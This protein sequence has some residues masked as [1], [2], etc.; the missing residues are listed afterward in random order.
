MSASVLRRTIKRTALRTLRSAGLYSVAAN[1]AARKH[2]LLILCYHGI[3]LR[4]EHKWAG[5]LFITADR[6]RQRLTCLRELGAEVLPLGEA[7]HRLTARNLPSR[8]VTITFDDGFYDFFH[9]AT[10]I[11][12]EF[13]YPAT[14]YLTTY[15]SGLRIPIV[16]LI[17]DYLLW[18][19]E[20]NSMRFPDQGIQEPVSITTWQERMQAVQRL[21][22]WCEAKKLDTWAKNEFARSVAE[23]LNIDYDDLLRSRIAQIMTP[24]EAA[25]AARKGIDIQLHSHRHRTPRDHDLFVRE[26]KDNSSRIEEITGKVPTHFCYPSGD[27]AHEFLPWLRECGVESA[28]TCERGFA[29]ANTEPLLLPRILDDSNMDIVEF[30]ALVS[31]LLA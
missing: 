22:S 6:L 1:S 21:L 11:L 4:D 5:H 18:K 28:T 24:D 10:P 27:Y 7:L 14:L 13:G 16:N 30:E 31:G 2:K 9:H 26:I 29:R 20:R 23:R 12:S 3:A 25:E 17:L 19:S 8:A 15:Y